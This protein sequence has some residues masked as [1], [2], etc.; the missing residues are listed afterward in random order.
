MKKI[1]HLLTLPHSNVALPVFWAEFWCG[2]MMD[3]TL[4]LG[5]RAT[6]FHET[7][8]YQENIANFDITPFLRSV[9]VYSLHLTYLDERLE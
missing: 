9:Q 1:K 7:G 6:V 2:E 5:D 8:S 3:S 4:V